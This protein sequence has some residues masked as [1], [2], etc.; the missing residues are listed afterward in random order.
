VTRAHLDLRPGTVDAVLHDPDIVRPMTPEEAALAHV[1]GIDRLYVA[2]LRPTDVLV[3]ECSEKITANMARGI[4]DALASVW[5]GRKVLV[6]DSG[7]TL[8]AVEGS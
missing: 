1:P 6:L 7:L 4:K 3:V 8:K 5:P 2:S